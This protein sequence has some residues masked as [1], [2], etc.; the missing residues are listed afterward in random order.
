MKKNTRIIVSII[1]SMIMTTSMGNISAYAVGN[2]TPVSEPQ[3]TLAPYSSNYWNTTSN[4]TKETDTK[5]YVHVSAGNSPVLQVYGTNANNTTSGVNCTRSNDT[6]ASISDVYVQSGTSLKINNDVKWHGANYT[7]YSRAYLR[8]ISSYS[9]QG[10]TT[11]I[12]WSSDTSSD[13]T[14]HPST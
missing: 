2:T 3:I 5:V 13:G 1:A 11:Y 10:G 9:Y 4:R 14:L 7:N 8:A 6:G 12:T